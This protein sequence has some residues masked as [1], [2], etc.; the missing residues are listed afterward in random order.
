[1]SRR[2]RNLPPTSRWRPT[3]TKS[4]MSRPASS[5]CRPPTARTSTGS[6]SLR[7]CSCGTSRRSEVAGPALNRR[8]HAS[9][10]HDVPPVAQRPFGL[11]DRHIEPADEAVARCL[12]GDRQKD[13]VELEQRIA[14]EIHLCHEPLGEAGAEKR[15]V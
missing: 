7:W 8:R 15:E 10:Q 2:K 5:L 14:R 9:A 4:L 13:R 6:S 12:I 11:G 3:P 1:T